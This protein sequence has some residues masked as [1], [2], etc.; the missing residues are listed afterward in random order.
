[1]LSIE[2]AGELWGSERALMDLFGG[3]RGVECAVCCPP[4]KPLVAVL[5]ERKIPCFPY[6]RAHLERR[7]RAQWA[8]AAMGVMRACLAFRPDVL[9]VNQAGAYRTCL[10]A[11]RL[12]G[13][14][15]VCHVRLFED[16]PYLAKRLRVGRSGMVL[17][18]ISESVAEALSAETDLAGMSLFTVYDAFSANESAPMSLAAQSKVLC[19]GRISASK[20]QEMLIQAVRK[21]RIHEVAT[22]EIIGTGDD[23]YVKKLQAEAGGTITFRGFD[24]DAAQRIRTGDLV[25][26]PSVREPLGRTILE[27]WSAGAMPVACSASGGAAEIIAKSSGGLLY[28]RP[29][30]DGLATALEE[31]WKMGPAARAERAAAGRVWLEDNCEPVRQGRGFHHI[32]AGL[33][34]AK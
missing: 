22:I 9:H 4:D 1:M 2:P 15:I 16:I 23:D 5:A 17:V 14:P 24:P 12:L 32:L 26:V 21:S 20:G 31:A 8:M 13:L 11:A 7:S 19:I 18:A 6:F 34:N 3:L 28:D 33:V 10:P 29:T 27:A 25:V 30:P